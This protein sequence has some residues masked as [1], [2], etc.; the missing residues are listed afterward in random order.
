MNVKNASWKLLHE[1]R[2]EQP[3]VPRQADEVGVVLLQSSHNFTIVISPLL[4]LRW[5]YQRSE[6]QIVSSFQPRCVRP[7]RNDHRDAGVA[8][9]PIRHITGNRFKI[10]TASGEKDA[11]VFH[12]SS[13]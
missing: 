12:R 3:S 9:S 10:G 13:W 8:N 11:E 1:P 7:V 5:N 2:R 4:A 6:S